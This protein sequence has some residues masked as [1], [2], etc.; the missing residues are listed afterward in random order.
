MKKFLAIILSAGMLLTLSACGK[1]EKFISSKEEAT[2]TTA[3]AETTPEQTQKPVAYKRVKSVTI[4]RE[5]EGTDTYEVTWDGDV[6]TFT[7]TEH[8]WDPCLTQADFDIE[9]GAFSVHRKPEQADSDDITD[10]TLCHFDAQQI[11]SSLTRPADL[12]QFA[13]SYNENGWPQ[14]EILS[15]L[16]VEIDE[17]KMQYAYSRAG[18]VSTDCSTT[19]YC[20][21][22]LNQK[23]NPIQVD[24][25]DV[26]TYN[27]G[28][29]EEKYEENTETYTYDADG[30]MLK[31][32]TDDGY[33]EFTYTDEVIH[34]NWERLI[35]LLSFD[36]TLIYTMPL[37]WNIQ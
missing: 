25:R 33:V 30:N 9:T 36:F 31:Y 32:A 19:S 24:Y 34:H 6:C 22:T 11:L 17:S 20:V 5:G 37:F 7:M 12:S 28:R 14:R 16:A 27:D 13:V 29:V 18:M 15:L 35:P 8:G 10:V 23:G 26:T 21:V 4:Y 3:P 2:E 1:E